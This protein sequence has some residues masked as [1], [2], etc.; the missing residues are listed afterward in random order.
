MLQLW[1]RLAVEDGPFQ[2]LALSHLKQVCGKINLVGADVVPVAAIV[3]GNVVAVVQEGKLV[4]HGIIGI[5]AG[6]PV[7]VFV[8]V[9]IVGSNVLGSSVVHV[10]IQVGKSVVQGIVGVMGINITDVGI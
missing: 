2:C 6:E 7:V 1:R 9:G 10:S 8:V 4:L 3:G 5:H